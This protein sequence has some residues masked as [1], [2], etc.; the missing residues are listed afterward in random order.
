MPV[1]YLFAVLVDAYDRETYSHPVHQTAREVYQRID[2]DVS[3]TMGYIFLNWNESPYFKAIRANVSKFIEKRESVKQYFAQIKKETQTRVML[4]TNS[5]AEYTDLLMKYAF[6]DDWKDSF[7]LIIYQSRKP[8]FF[9]SPIPQPTSNAPVSSVGSEKTK[10]HSVAPYH[11]P[12]C[13]LDRITPVSLPLKLGGEYYGGNNKD[14]TDFFISVQSSSSLSPSPSL[15]ATTSPSVCYVGDELVGDV[16]IPKQFCNWATVAIVE[17]LES[18]EHSL[19]LF[20][21]LRSHSTLTTASHISRGFSSFFHPGSESTDVSFFLHLM[22]HHSDHY[23]SCLTKL[24]QFSPS[25]LFLTHAGDSSQVTFDDPSSSASQL[26]HI[27]EYVDT[28]SLPLYPTLAIV[29]KAVDYRIAQR[30][31][32]HDDTVAFSFNAV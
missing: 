7:D 19:G 29:Q 1:G 3:K 24:S 9:S 15:P 30:E 8:Y 28:E 11:S 27:L 2:R 26:S 32:Q 6:G 13:E 16:W 18:L 31:E 20:S 4:M 17:E 21:D 14:L 23:T 22:H 12:F 10:S 5:F 25:H